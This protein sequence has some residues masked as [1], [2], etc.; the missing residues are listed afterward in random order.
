MN[1]SGVVV[2]TKA[3]SVALVKEK[4]IESGLCEVHKSDPSGKIIITIEGKTIKDET[5]K[6]QQIQTIDGVLSADMAY[7]YSE[8]DYVGKEVFKKEV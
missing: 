3:G 5:E 2:R 6:L 8:H 1:I 7:A 4:L